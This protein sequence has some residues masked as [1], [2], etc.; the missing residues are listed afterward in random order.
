M[1]IAH[2]RAQSEEMLFLELYFFGGR[3]PALNA[4]VKKCLPWL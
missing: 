2:K 1:A 3:K 4:Q